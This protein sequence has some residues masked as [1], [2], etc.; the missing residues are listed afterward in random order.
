M[1]N[2]LEELLEKQNQLLER[3]N[4]LLEEVR[5]S[6]QTQNVPQEWI[7][8]E[9]AAKIVGLRITKS[10]NHRRRLARAAEKGFITKFRPGKPPSYY[11]PELLQLSA[12]IRAHQVYI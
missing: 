11:V 2:R 10:N 1:S 7:D 8:P 4:L 5:A 12:R 9:G 3:N 6:L